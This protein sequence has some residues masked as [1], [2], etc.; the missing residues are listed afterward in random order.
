MDKDTGW[1]KL[2]TGLTFFHAVVQERRKFGALGWNIRYEFNDTDLET[3]L[4]S[5]RKFLEEQPLVP[6]DALRYV[7]GQINYGGR[8]TDDWD[9]RCLLS[10]LG[11]YY[12]P[13]ILVDGYAFSQSG[14]YRVPATLA[15]HGKVLAY[16]NDL[17]QLDNPELFGMHENANVT[18]ERNESMHMTRLI[19]SLEPR[20]SGGGGAKSN[21]QRV[22]ELAASIQESL[23]PNLSVDDAGPTTFKTREVAGTVVMDSLATVLGQELVKFNTL[24]NRMRSSLVDV[25]RAI[26]GL[27]VMSSDLDNMYTAFLNGRLPQIWGQVS[28]ASLRPLGSWVQDLL[29]RV[30]FFR[31]W[32]LHGEPVVFDLHVFFFPQGFMTGTLQNFARKYQVAIDSLAFTFSVLDVDSA[33]ELSVSPSDGIYVDGLWVQGARWSRSQAQLVDATPGEMFSPMNLVHFLPASNVERDRTQYPCPV[34][35]TSVRQGTLSTTGISTNFVIAVYLPTDRHP[36]Y[37]V[38]NGTAFLLNLDT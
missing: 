2:L 21:D 38:M 20:D 29:Q 8:V 6:W 25:Q 26:N 32:L 36:D 27:I 13:H 12:T 31:T 9:R 5:L 22:L 16:L 28:F 23:P 35:K 1:R 33:D 24:L 3:S 18:Y 7:T 19:L 34:Y 4:A 37:W 30:V 15:V 17:P 14:T 10:I 11:N